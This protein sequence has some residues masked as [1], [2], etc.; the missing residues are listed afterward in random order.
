[1]NESIVKSIVKSI[2]F[3]SY[4]IF[5]FYMSTINLEMKEIITMLFIVAIMIVSNNITDY[6]GDKE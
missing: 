1:M 5:G 3:I 4:F 2:S 6:L